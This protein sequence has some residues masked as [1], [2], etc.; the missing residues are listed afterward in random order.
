MTGFR[1]VLFRS[2]RLFLQRDSTAAGKV[3]QRRGE[4]KEPMNCVSGV[5]RILW[6]GK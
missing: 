4:E 3:R 2:L 6:D 1:R 5:L